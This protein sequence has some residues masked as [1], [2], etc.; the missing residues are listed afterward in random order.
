MTRW[1]ISRI[2]VC[3]EKLV[4]PEKDSCEDCHIVGWGILRV[5]AAIRAGWKEG[6]K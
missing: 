3:N 2:R 4:D 6:S 1:H 5:A